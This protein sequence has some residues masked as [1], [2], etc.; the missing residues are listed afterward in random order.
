MIPLMETENK[1]WKA[2][3]TLEAENMIIREAEIHHL[4]EETEYSRSPEDDSLMLF[5]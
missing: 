2:A 3:L 1:Q 4:S 5:Y